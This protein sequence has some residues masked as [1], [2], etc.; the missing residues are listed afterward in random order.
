MRD[1]QV[2][3]VL[4]ETYMFRI[5]NSF[6]PVT[7][8]ISIRATEPEQQQHES[9]KTSGASADSRKSQHA[10]IDTQILSPYFIGWQSRLEILKGEHQKARKTALVLRTFALFS[11]KFVCTNGP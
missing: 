11:G 6:S 9:A 3:T 8:C 2:D 4:F 5:R 1:A 7:L 10:E